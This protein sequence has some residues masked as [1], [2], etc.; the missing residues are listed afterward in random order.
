MDFSDDEVL[1]SHGD[2]VCRVNWMG[3]REEYGRVDW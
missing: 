2:G 1:K 3:E